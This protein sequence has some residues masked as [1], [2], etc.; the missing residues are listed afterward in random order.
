MA[1]QASSR[2][3][4]IVTYFSLLIPGVIWDP[5]DLQ[6]F[7]QRPQHITFRVCVK[8]CQR[9][10]PGCGGNAPCVGTRCTNTCTDYESKPPA[11]AKP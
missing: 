9:L 2:A 3:F 6:E 5:V 7:D 11:R 4:F 8:N 1:F 10:P